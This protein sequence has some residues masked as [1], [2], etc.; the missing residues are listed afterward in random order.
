MLR[1]LFKSE[2]RVIRNIAL[3]G[4]GI[5]LD[6]SV[7]VVAQWYDCERMEPVHFNRDFRLE[8]DE[9]DLGTIDGMSWMAAVLPN[10]LGA[11]VF[12]TVEKGTYKPLLLHLL[13]GEAFPMKYFATYIRN[14]ETM[15]NHLAA[16]QTKGRSAGSHGNEAIEAG[17]V[18]EG[19]I[20]EI[21][22]KESAYSRILVVGNDICFLVLPEA[23]SPTMCGAR[24]E[25][26]RSLEC[27][28]CCYLDGSKT[29]C[30]DGW[31]TT[32]IP[33]SEYKLAATW[34]PLD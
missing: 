26:I 33:T 28:V 6:P 2:R 19:R 5:D 12:L 4:W 32:Q 31:I 25:L 13:G 23:T 34:E 21:S 10:T 30:L 9:R 1:D 7:G 29:V 17:K 16:S 8:F 27:E 14:I 11:E 20:K 15:L 24:H 3:S 22:I 18:L